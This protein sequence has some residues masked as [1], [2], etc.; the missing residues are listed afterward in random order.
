MGF[1]LK[2]LKKSFSKVLKVAQVVAP[3]AAGFFPGGGAAVGIASKLGAFGKVAGTVARVK[4]RIQPA[5][6]LAKTVQKFKSRGKGFP[7]LPSWEAR[8]SVQGPPSGLQGRV[9]SVHAR[10]IARL[11]SLKRVSSYGNARRY[12]RASMMK[13]PSAGMGMRRARS[14]FMVA[15]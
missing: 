2:K 15:R 6:T 5:L 10:S 8:Q 1:S 14:R 7:G 11:R 4:Q 12:R 13:R 9:G 3:I